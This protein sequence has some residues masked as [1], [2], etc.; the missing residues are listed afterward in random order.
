MRNPNP[1]PRTPYYKNRAPYYGP[2]GCI[3][4]RADSTRQAPCDDFS[5]IGRTPPHDRVC[6]S[7]RFECFR[8]SICFPGRSA[9]ANR[10]V[11]K[12]RGA[13]WISISLT[14][15]L[16]L[17]HPRHRTIRSDTV[18]NFHTRKIKHARLTS[19]NATGTTIERSRANSKRTT[20][21]ATDGCRGEKSP[22]QVAATG[23]RDT[24]PTRPGTRKNPYYGPRNPSVSRKWNPHCPYYG[25]QNPYYGSRDPSNACHPGAWPAEERP[26]RVC[27]GPTPGR[28]S[29]VF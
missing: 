11:F 15:Q 18:Y 4:P 9:C 21:H 8:L 27:R 10:S 2:C 29:L 1:H 19:N 12:S 13:L 20:Q 7:L 5:C 26:P 28:K 24:S 14:T 25:K 3:G 17:N 22:R 23:R 16:A 6:A